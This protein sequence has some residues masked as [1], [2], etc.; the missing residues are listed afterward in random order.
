VSQFLYLSIV[1][2]V[3]VVVEGMGVGVGVGGGVG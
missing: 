2:R 3:G 1:D